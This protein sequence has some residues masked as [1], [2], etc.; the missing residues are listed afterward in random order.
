[1]S[2]FLIVFVFGGLISAFLAI[3]AGASSFGMSK[4]DHDSEVPQGPRML[5]HFLSAIIVFAITVILSSLLIDKVGLF[6]R[7]LPLI[8]GVM[9]AGAVFKIP[10]FYTEVAGN[11]AKVAVP[12]FG[13]T[14]GDKGIVLYRIFLSGFKWKF[15]W[16]TFGKDSSVDLEKDTTISK[17]IEVEF[18]DG[19]G[20]LTWVATMQP[21]KNKIQQLLN[22]G[23][24]PDERKKVLEAVFTSFF[25]SL[26][27][28][29]CKGEKIDEIMGDRKK[30]IQKVVG[31][32]AS[33]GLEEKELMYGISLN[34]F[35]ISDIDYSSEDRKK[36]KEQMA[37]A[38]IF[39]QTV[40]MILKRRGFTDEQV[41]KIG[42]KGGVPKKEYAE[43]VRLAKILSDEVNAWDINISGIENLQNLHL[44]ADAARMMFAAGGQKTGR[45]GNQQKPFSGQKS[46]NGKGEK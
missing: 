43:A 30:I 28:V 23:I 21:N 37:V 13:G 4:E 10:A 26:I 35:V 33:N 5:F 46:G 45:Q 25:N 27:G 18:A 3:V 16:E 9:F 20:K 17:S 39:M 7:P 32:K 19:I 24:N 12:L 14:I 6:N 36:A 22:I 42:K 40:V 41:G 8:L 34:S 31:D 15:P 1:M 44:P 2:G 29:A 38:D 11:T